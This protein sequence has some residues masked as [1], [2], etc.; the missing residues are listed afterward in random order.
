MIDT[1]LTSVVDDSMVK[2]MG[3]FDNEWGYANRC[4]DLLSE[5]RHMI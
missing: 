4:A 3:W 1:A 2:V 5:L